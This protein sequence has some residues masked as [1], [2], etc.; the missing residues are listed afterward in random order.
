MTRGR[1]VALVLGVPFALLLIGWAGITELAFAAQ[2]TNSLRLGLPAHPRAL[3]L[4]AN[5]GDLNVR[6]AAGTSLRVT[7]NITY[8]LLRPSV[9]WRRTPSGVIVTSHCR[10]A[11]GQCSFDYQAFLP[12]GTRLLLSNGSGDVTVTGLSA[13][14]V[15]AFDNRGNITLTFSSVPD[16]V[17]VVDQLGDVT[18]VLP[19]G[20]TAYQ[21]S[22]QASLGSTSISVPRSPAS[23]HVISVIVQNGDVTIR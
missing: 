3:E 2:G 17:R 1:W 13:T 21:V 6:E 8:W 22:A 7:G 4:S 16:Q 15:T 18:L 20:G 14:H 11:E 5:V 12:A 9:S 10:F 19:P 23:A